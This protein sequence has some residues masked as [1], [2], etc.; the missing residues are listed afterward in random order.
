[1]LDRI[2]AEEIELLIDSKGKLWIN[3]DGRCEIRIGSCKRVYVEKDGKGSELIYPP[4][5]YVPVDDAVGD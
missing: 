4:A 2:R 3:V 1:M 5:K